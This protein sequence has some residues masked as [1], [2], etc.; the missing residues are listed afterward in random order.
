MMFERIKKVE[1]TF[2]E[3][4]KEQPIVK[5]IFVKAIILLKWPLAL[6]LS[7][8]AVSKE[9][10]ATLNPRSLAALSR[11]SHCRSVSG[12]PVGSCKAKRRPWIWRSVLILAV[13]IFF[14]SP[15]VPK[16]ISGTLLALANLMWDPTC[17][18]KE[19]V[20]IS[21]LLLLLFLALEIKWGR[22]VS[23]EVIL[24]VSKVHI[25]FWEGHK[26]HQLFVLCTASQI[27]GGDFAKFC[28]L[29]RIYEL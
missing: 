25:P 10:P 27:I 2:I 20:G 22:I 28:G 6:L 9:T 12:F 13:W 26:I 14:N 7:V 3:C 17:A 23:E 21:F 11:S 18:K 29:L 16:D 8:I 4:P 5:A 15:K 24:K 1:S 19:K